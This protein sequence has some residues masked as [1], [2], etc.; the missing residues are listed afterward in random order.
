[1]L[2]K[3]V[4]WLVSNVDA[5]MT[6][7]KCIVR[8]PVFS[9]QSNEF[10]TGFVVSTVTVDACLAFT[11][12]TTASLLTPSALTNAPDC[13]TSHVVLVEIPIPRSRTLLRSLVLSMI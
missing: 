3:R 4:S 2:D 6:S 11:P 5:L 1:M 7:E 13:S 12:F 9:F 10:I 8:I